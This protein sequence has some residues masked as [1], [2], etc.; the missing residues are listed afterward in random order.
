VAMTDE[1]FINNDIGIYA[2]DL[3]QDNI[4][5]AINSIEWLAD[6]SGL[7]RLRNKFTTFASLQPID[8]SRKNFLKY[9]NFLLPLIATI[10]FAAI[11]FQKNRKR[12]LNRSRTGYIE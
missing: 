12:R 7:I 1:D 8:E 3:R 11:R 10:T 2:H 9:F 6:N 4:N 5:F